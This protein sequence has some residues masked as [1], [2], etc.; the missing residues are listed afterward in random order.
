MI[1]KGCALTEQNNGILGVIGGL[2]PL[3]T[4]HFMELVIRMTRAERDQDHLD[5]IVYSVPSI[6]DRTAYILDG[7]KPSP[8]PGMIRVG[9]KLREQNA[10]CVVIPCFTAHYFYEE[11]RGGI[12]L[13]IINALRETAAYLRRAGVRKAGIMATDGTIRS[14]LFHRELLVQGIEPVE[15]SESGQQDV[16]ALIYE[17]IKQNRPADMARFRRVSD[18]L[19]SRGAEVIILG[20]TELSMI[21]RD[22]AIGPG[23]IDAMEVLAAA[24]VRMCGGALSDSGKNLI[25]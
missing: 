18:E 23:F 25:T 6:P 19:R 24:S 22:N 16:M 5:M 4:A 8:L 10:A 7:T 13:P 20:C 17:D 21:K 9:Q 11:L 12:G 15:P 1:K 3:A 14:K 2:G